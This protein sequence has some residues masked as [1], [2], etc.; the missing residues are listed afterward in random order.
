[1][2]AKSVLEFEYQPGHPRLPSRGSSA[3]EIRRLRA[4]DGLACPLAEFASLRCSPTFANAAWCFVLDVVRSVGAA[5]APQGVRASGQ[6]P[7]AIRAGLAIQRPS[8]LHI[9]C[10]AMRL[11]FEPHASDKNHGLLG[12]PRLERFSK[13]SGV[14]RPG[15]G[16]V[17]QAKPACHPGPPSGSRH[18]RGQVCRARVAKQSRPSHA[19]LNSRAI[20]VIRDGAGLVIRGLLRGVFSSVP[21][22]TAPLGARAASL[23]AASALQR[24]CRRRS[25]IDR[26]SS[27]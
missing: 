17:Q 12:A 1:M 4:A 8:E 7:P 2:G 16:F 25:P 14:P 6:P 20:A 3:R 10:D 11:R 19:P 26:D 13:N 18:H 23:F 27:T 5:D 24:P 22:A 15:L 9:S 21:S